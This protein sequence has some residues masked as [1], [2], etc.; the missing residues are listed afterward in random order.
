[1]VRRINVS[2][3]ADTHG[4]LDWI[5]LKHRT[6]VQSVTAKT[7]AIKTGGRQVGPGKVDVDQN[8]GAQSKR[9]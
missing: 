7:Y 5:E 8:R 6:K 4:G 3:H 9:N 2:F 1:V